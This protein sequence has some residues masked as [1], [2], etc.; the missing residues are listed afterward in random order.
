M[1]TDF[2]RDPAP[3]DEFFGE[4]ADT[5]DLVD[6][7]TMD[8][9]SD[10]ELDRRRE[11]IMGRIHRPATSAK[12]FPP[13]DELHGVLVE[14]RRERRR[15][16]PRRLYSLAAAVVL[17]AVLAAGSLFAGSVWF[18]GKSGSADSIRDPRDSSQL[19]PLPNSQNGPGLGGPDLT[20][21]HL[22]GTDP[23]TGVSATVAL[24]EKD[25]GTQISFA[26]SSLGGPRKCRLVIVHTDGT[27]EPVATW[28]V[29]QDGWGTAANPQALLLQAITST[30]REDIAHLQV[31]EIVANQEDGVTLVRVP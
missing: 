13:R 19:D 11:E 27:T 5:I 28:D 14:V 15:A 2:G 1:T 9:I 24:A 6:T 29:G 3:E 10:Q 26:V 23:R 31:Q 4:L 22:S 7:M 17:F 8:R 30:P 20:G 16:A 12:E 21:Q 18:G 25:W